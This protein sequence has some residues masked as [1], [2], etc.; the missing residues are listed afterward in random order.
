MTPTVD[1]ATT[2]EGSPATGH[3]VGGRGRRPIRGAGGDDSL[4]GNAGNDR[5]EGGAGDDILYGVAGDDVLDGGAGR[6][7]LSGHAGAD[8]LLARDG[9][10]DEVECAASGE[11]S[12]ASRTTARRVDTVDSD[13]WC[14]HVTGARRLVLHGLKPAGVREARIVV[15]CQRRMR[16][17]ARVWVDSGRVL[18]GC[19]CRRDSA[20]AFSSAGSATRGWRSASPPRRVA[21]VASS[22]G[23]G[24]DEA[25]AGAPRRRSCARRL[26]QRRRSPRTTRPR[27][28]RTAPTTSATSSSRPHRER[29]TGSSCPGSRAAAYGCVIRWGSPRR[30]RASPRMRRRPVPV[31]RRFRAQGEPGRRQ[32]RRDDVGRRLRL[33][34]RGRRHRRPADGTG[35]RR[36]GS[37]H[38]DREGLPRRGA[39]RA[40]RGRA[41][42]RQARLRRPR[43]RCDGR[44]RCRHGDLRDDVDRLEPGTW[45]LA[46]GDGPDV[47]RGAGTGLAD[48]TPVRETT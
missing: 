35:R 37:R 47:I 12:R 20:R 30:R 26:R 18:R 43:H 10:R 23:S 48:S 29:S 17:P 25:A 42:G 44:S 45:L 40:G 36:P 22:L 28:T 7:A 33:R 19:G 31:H 8:R 13:S 15:S 46:T 3:I 2:L 34:R 27:A 39:R 5:L 24:A 4:F 41:R 9:E 38:A 14:D 32:R 16:L 6:D 1:P 21:L 11:T